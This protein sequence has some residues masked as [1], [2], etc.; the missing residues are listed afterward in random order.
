MSASSRIYIRITVGNNCRSTHNLGQYRLVKLVDKVNMYLLFRG[1]MC[2]YLKD[3]S[4]AIADYD[5]AIWLDPY[6]YSGISR[7]R[8]LAKMPIGD[9]GGS[10]MDY[11]IGWVLNGKE[12]FEK[13]FSSLQKWAGRFIEGIDVFNL[14]QM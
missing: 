7:E 11:S 1:D 4:G 5:A 10:V 8:A 13:E 12:N 3:A 2:S 14:H 9:V 6:F